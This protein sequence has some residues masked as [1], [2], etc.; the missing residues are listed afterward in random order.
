M[1]KSKKAIAR[2]E[3]KAAFLA[4]GKLVGT[5]LAAAGI[6]ARE[7]AG[8]VMTVCVQDKLPDDWVSIDARKLPTV[9]REWHTALMDTLKADNYSAPNMVWKRIRAEGAAMYKAAAKKGPATVDTPASKREKVRELTEK[10]IQS[11]YTRIK[12]AEDVDRSILNLLPTLRD[13]ASSIG[14]TLKEPE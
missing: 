2:E 13:M 8:I 1:S 6:S 3:Q 12:K 11:M 4:A 5:G 7:A 10:D 14:F 9:L